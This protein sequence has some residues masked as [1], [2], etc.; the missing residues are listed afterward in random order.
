LRPTDLEACAA[1][2]DKPDLALV[3][4]DMSGMGGLEFLKKSCRKGRKFK[5]IVIAK[6]KE[7]ARI[8]KE[9]IPIDGHLGEPFDLE[10]LFDQIQQL[11]GEPT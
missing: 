1:S 3:Q 5:I 4:F 2:G 8:Q 7:L 9:K 6:K 11:I 10:D